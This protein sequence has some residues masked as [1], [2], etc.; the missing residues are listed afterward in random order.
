MQFGNEVILVGTVTS[1][2]V[3]T[4]TRAYNGSTAQ[5][6][7]AGMTITVGNT[8]GTAFGTNNADMFAH[9]GFIALSLNTGDSIQFTWQVGVTS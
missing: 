7:T 5:A 6:A 8:P 3:Y 1:N 9:A 4:V 2:T